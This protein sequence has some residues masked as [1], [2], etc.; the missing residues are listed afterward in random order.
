MR[1]WPTISPLLLWRP[2]N[3]RV[4]LEMGTVNTHASHFCLTPWH[5]ART[6][7]RLTHFRGRETR[8]RSPSKVNEGL[9]GKERERERER[10]TCFCVRVN[11]LVSMETN[12]ALLVLFTPLIFPLHSSDASERQGRGIGKHNPEKGL[13]LLLLLPS[14]KVSVFAPLSSFPMTRY[15]GVEY[16]TSNICVKGIFFSFFLK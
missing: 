11:T 5:C 8:A 2:R 10:E 1:R 12:G 3:S 7:T 13:L 4:V 16:F 14:K 9:G 6:H 15:T